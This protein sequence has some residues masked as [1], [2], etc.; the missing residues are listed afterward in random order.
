M[1]ARTLALAA[2]LIL[3]TLAAAPASGGESR[4]LTATFT[5]Q[6]VAAEPRC[7]DALTLG[8]EIN[9]QSAHLG[10]FTGVGSN[11]TE[12]A[13]ATTAVAVWD[14]N[15]AFFASDGSTITTTSQ[16][17]QAAPVGG[18]ANFSIDHTLTGGTG[19]FDGVSGAW[20]VT[21]V[22]DFTT[23]TITGQATGWL[24]K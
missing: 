18:R 5:G 20:K 3:A 6:A 14:G 15:S 2:G 17:S 12:W 11:C 16:G 19:R 23:G 10:S 1:M 8:F 7:G 21:G 4:P 13:L 9:G 22:I 24:S